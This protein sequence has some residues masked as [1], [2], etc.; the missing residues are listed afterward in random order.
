MIHHGTYLLKWADWLERSCYRGSA[1][2]LVLE[3]F[4]D[5]LTSASARGSDPEVVDADVS[6]SAGPLAARER[7]PM[8]KWT[9][10]RWLSWSLVSMD[11]DSIRT[12]TWRWINLQVGNI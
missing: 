7:T 10:L 1:P 12:R 9:L 3:C 4:F 8:W 6:G 5:D 2:I 11:V